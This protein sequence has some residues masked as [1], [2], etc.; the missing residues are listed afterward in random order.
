[1]L[2][3][4][5]KRWFFLMLTG[6]GVLVVSRPAW[7]SWTVY[8][9]PRWLVATTLLLA[10][11]CM[12]GGRLLNAVARPLPV[13][14][15]AGFSYG[16]TPFFAWS[17]GHL[18][19]PDFRIGLLIIACVP[20]TLGSAIVWTR[21]AGGNEATALLVIVLTTSTC[22]LATPLLLSSILGAEVALDPSGL[23]L[24]LFLALVVPLAIG[25]L[26]RRS[27]WVVQRVR[28]WRKPI[29]VLTQITVLL[30]I[31]KA[32]VEA[33]SRLLVHPETISLFS[34][35]AVCMLCL[36]A[37]LYALYAGY[38]TSRAAGFSVGDQVAIAIAGSQKTLPVA[39]ML[40]DRSFRQYPLALVSI[41]VYH[42]GQLVLDTFIAEHWNGRH[43]S[44]E[45]KQTSMEMPPAPVSIEV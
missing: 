4:V 31:L 34:A 3:F 37:H 9:E 13:L 5:R 12:E 38:W 40:F 18:L 43:S 42:V 19:L 26:L 28:E 17:L 29:G 10:A 45:R 14:W 16:V 23:M 35:I 30:V 39:L 33:R 20:C 36:S 44:L 2:E 32:L 15:A 41:L 25:Q 27:I 8:I 1:M 6:S 24:G 21:L 22:W 11:L 7:L